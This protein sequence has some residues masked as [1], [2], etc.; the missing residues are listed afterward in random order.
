LSWLKNSWLTFKSSWSL[1]KVK[2][3]SFR[4]FSSLLMT[5]SN[6]KETLSLK[7]SLKE[8]VEEGITDQ[9]M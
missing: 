6:H 7:G 2:A 8:V 1:Q 3:I 4:A 9:R 5:P